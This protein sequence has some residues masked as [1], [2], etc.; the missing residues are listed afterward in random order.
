MKIKE[1]IKKYREILSYLFFG[2]ATTVINVAIYH[3]CYNMLDIGNS[4]STVI[5]WFVSVAFAF[6]T[7]KIFVFE[8]RSAEWN[9]TLKEAM[10]FFGCRIGS[11]ALE[12]GIMYFF[13]D[14]LFFNGTIMK[15]ITN[16]I[17]IVLNFV[18]SKLFIF[19]KNR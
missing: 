11:G 8:S 2:G 6:V 9:K 5:A 13:V 10:A 4:I 1:I 16:I 14:V 19:K 7:N 18:F 15:L 17:V 12:L 3:V